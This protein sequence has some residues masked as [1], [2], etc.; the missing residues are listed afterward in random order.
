[1]YIRINRNCSYI[2]TLLKGKISMGDIHIY[3]SSVK[4]IG[5]SVF[6]LHARNSRLISFATNLRLTFVQLLLE[7]LENVMEGFLILP[8]Y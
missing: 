2:V 6:M 4:S 1:M 7:A 3:F 5:K 8:G